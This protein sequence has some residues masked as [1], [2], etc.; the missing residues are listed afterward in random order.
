MP[1]GNVVPAGSASIDE[2]AMIE[3]LAIGAH[4][5][6]RGGITADDRVLVVGSGPIGMSAIISRKHAA[7]MSR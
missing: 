2:A 5:A 4:G 6:K 1:V 3:F 7:P